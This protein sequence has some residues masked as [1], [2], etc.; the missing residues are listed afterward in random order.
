MKCFN[1]KKKGLLLWLFLLPAISYAQIAI[2]GRVFDENGE[3]VAGATIIVKGSTRG[4]F[5]DLNGKFTIE[6]KPTDV[7]EINFIGYQI[8]SILVGEQRNFDIRLEPKVNELDEVTIVAFGKQRKESVIGAI[9]TVN[10]KDLKVPSSNMTTALAGNMAGIIAYQRSGEPGQDNADFFVRGIT[11]FGS[12]IYPLILI[13]GIELTSTDLA[14][15]QPDDIAS[16]SI[17]KDA[18]ATAL[19]G[20]RGA[21]GVILVTTKQGSEGPAKISL[22][23]ENSFSMPTRN[24]ELA[25]PITYMTLSNEAVSTRDPL[26]LRPYSEDKIENTALGKDPLYYPANDWMDM[27]L[28]KYTMNQRANL[29]ITGGGGVAR[30]YV[31]ASF[32][33]DNG[34]LKV[35]KRQNFNN[36]IDNKTYTMRANVNI[37]LTKT[38]ELSIRLS[39]AFDDYSGPITGGA[40]MY[41]LIYGA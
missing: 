15:L 21:N 5:T 29:S 16:F 8:Y 23:L 26:G 22:R 27:L 38:T 34:I 30:Y 10:V 31:G 1:L 32:S 14:R 20:A 3:S 41:N 17:M 13:D 11:T 19:Y 25:D 4:V 2:T 37:D 12:N 6:V 35:D 9:T 36:N 33:Q 28:R 24:V 40:D 7:L 39:G 18:T